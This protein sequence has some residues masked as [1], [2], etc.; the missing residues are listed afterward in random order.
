MTS[1]PVKETVPFFNLPGGG[2]PVS[3]S[4]TD[5]AGG[6]G[7][8]MN[9]TS[10]GGNDYSAGNRVN[11]A[12]VPK[13][14]VNA[15]DARKDA[16][17]AQSARRTV[18]PE[19]TTPGQEQ[20][21]EAAGEKLVDETAKE[22]GVSKEEVLDAMEELGLGMADL[23]NA[24]NLTDLVLTLS[25]ADGALA[26]LTDE[27][28]YG[29]MQ[30][31]LELLNGIQTE[32]ME[33]FSMTPEE[34]QTLLESMNA[35]NQEEGANGANYS[36]VL[37][38]TGDAAKQQAAPITVT[39]EQGNE[40]VRLTADEKGN[41]EQV[42]E[43]VVNR[44]E[45]QEKPSDEK[46]KGGFAG[47]SEKQGFGET[48]PMLDAL[49]KNPVSDVDASFELAAPVQNADP[50]EIM[51]Q[52]LDY[53]KIQLKPGMEQLEMQL[54]PESLGTLHIQLTSRGGEITAQFHVQNEA[55]KAALESQIVEL[56]DSLREQG[57]KVEA[58]EVTVES[59]AF[60]S[61]LWQGQERDDGASY[62][63]G[64]KSHRR[65]NLNAL[66]ED[67]EQSADEEE[68]LTAE[69]MRVNGG[70]VDYTA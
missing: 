27:T 12:N 35:E 39:V 54:H 41:T 53:M 57:V 58:V 25:G 2:K 19:K 7:D 15:S 23:L 44:E 43:V 36:D 56:K 38:Q 26:L 37:N 67:F 59:H 69:M 11:G 50:Q 30:N 24:D 68:K 70:T 22:L 34:F 51:R 28:L 9:R 13:T 32:L 3:G 60:E 48:N 63:S 1:T 66:D 65:I 21:V 29:K 10:Y 6:F 16:L 47:G 31:L 61:N 64:K 4:R 5:L 52:I 42:Q 49:F 40:T 17:K 46:G 45:P 33:E 8:V 20:A 14:Q 18:K 62:Q 55:V